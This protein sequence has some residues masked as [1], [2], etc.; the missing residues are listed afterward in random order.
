[1]QNSAMPAWSGAISKPPPQII[2]PRCGWRRNLTDCWC[3][4]GNAHLKTGKAQEAIALYLQALTLNPGH[5]PARTNLV[6]ALMA[7]RQYSMA[8]ALLLELID[9]R[10]QDG[11]IRH[12]LGKTYFELN[13]L[14]SALQCFEQAIVLDPG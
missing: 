13:E 2:R 7:T 4:L 5:W 6:Q 11:Q 9:E 8:R 12:Q 10:P 1:M 3:N 14:E